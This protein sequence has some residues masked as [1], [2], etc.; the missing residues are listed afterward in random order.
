MKKIDSGFVDEPSIYNT[1]KK[2]DKVGRHMVSGVKI[3]LTTQEDAFA[4][5]VSSILDSTKGITLGGICRGMSELQ[6][7]LEHTPAPIVVIDID[8][9]PAGVLKELDKLV[10]MYPKTR[11]A[12][13]SSTSNQALILEA[14][15]AGA[16]HFLHKKVLEAELDVVLERLL[17]GGVKTE[18]ATGS[19]ISV[20]S[21]GGGCGATT[22]ALNL[23]NELR[24]KSAEP[25][26]VIDLDNCRGA[27]SS[28]LRITGR[29]S[30]A[31]VLAYNGPIDKNLIASSAS[32]YVSGFDVL[33]SPTDL[34]PFAFKS[35]EYAN[36]TDALEACRQAYG[37]TIIDAPRVSENVTSFLATIS[38]VILI[39]FQLTVKDIKV[40][41]LM[42]STLIKLGARPASI[43]PLVNRFRSRGLMVP[44]E[45]TQKALGLDSLHCIRNDFRKI[46]TC[47]NRGET[48]AESAP[49]SRIRRDFL[50]LAATIYGYEEN[51]NG[52]LRRVTNNG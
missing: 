2:T 29:Y 43:V 16:R 32:S 50:N 5:K 14:M 31:D 44:L 35:I 46:V 9:N 10:P 25:V 40:A 41:G 51:G 24:L 27:V 8:P 36:L 26:L 19:V 11:F 42:K 30:V 52:Q 18:A 48:L 20:F 1:D 45:A 28:Y 6:A 37:Y 15:Q 34:D 33:V 47:I 12:V 3:L 38:R 13:V 22:V 17:S 7:N 49:R 23:A 4:Q 39:V 21:A